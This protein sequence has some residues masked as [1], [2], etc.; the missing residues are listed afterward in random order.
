MEE[1]KS[2]FYSKY[3][4]GINNKRLKAIVLITACQPSIL[5]GWLCNDKVREGIN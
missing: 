1:N 4:Q 2:L 5:G 3:E